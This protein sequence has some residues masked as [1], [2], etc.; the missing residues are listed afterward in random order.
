MKQKIIPYNCNIYKPSLIKYHIMVKIDILF[1]ERK[2]SRISEFEINRYTNF[3]ESSYKDNLEHS[4]FNLDIFPR[5]SIISGYYS[6]HDI[7]KLFIAKKLKIKVDF[8]VH[9]TTIKILREIIKNKELGVLLIKGYKEFLRLA[10]DLEEAKNERTKAQYYT[11]T[12]FLKDEYAK[13]AIEFYEEIVLVYIE[14]IK[15]LLGE[16]Q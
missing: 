13:R 6:M 8:E 7:T 9:S 15:K 11:G 16:L 12:K 3:F 14:K 2:I 10:N 1:N 4:K 5:W